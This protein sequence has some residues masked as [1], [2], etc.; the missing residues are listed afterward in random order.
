M[1]LTSTCAA[2]TT[3][4][5]TGALESR[6]KPPPPLRVYDAKT[7]ERMCE[8]AQTSRV[9][10]FALGA[11]LVAADSHGDVRVWDPLGAKEHMQGASLLAV[12]RAE[13]LPP[14]DRRTTC[15]NTSGDWCAAGM[16]DGEAL[17]VWRRGWAPPPPFCL[18]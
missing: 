5:A 3:L 8:V 17:F 14:P 12:L 7:G 16:A 15:L 18:V 11:L 13:S 2:N 10:D 1:V 4:I 9:C 6:A